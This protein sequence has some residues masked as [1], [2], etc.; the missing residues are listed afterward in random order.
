MK[1]ISGKDSIL[2]SPIIDRTEKDLWEFLNGMA[3]HHCELYDMG[4][5]RIGCILCP[6]SS[7]KEKQK[8]IKL[9]PHVKRNWLYT[10]KRM[11]ETGACY[12]LLKCPEKWIPKTPEREYS[13]DEIAENIFDYWIS[14]KSHSVWYADKFLQQK[15]DFKDED[16]DKEVK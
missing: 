5:K 14:D 3:I 13:N 2:V 4:Q 7:S 11:R 10:I 6:M 12:G 16:K 9:F 8:D 1:C 15:L